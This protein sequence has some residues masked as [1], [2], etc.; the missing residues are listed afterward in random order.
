MDTQ[1]EQK[2]KKLGELPYLEII[3]TEKNYKHSFHI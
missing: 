3:K 1:M 2:K